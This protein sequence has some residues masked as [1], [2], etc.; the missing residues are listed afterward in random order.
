MI[1]GKHLVE[2]LKISKVAVENLKKDYQELKEE[3]KRLK[4]ENM[5]LLGIIEKLSKKL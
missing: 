1:E 3:N 5:K 2:L 4:E